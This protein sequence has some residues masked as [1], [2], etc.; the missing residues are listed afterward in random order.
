MQVSRTPLANMNSSKCVKVSLFF[1]GHFA[2]ILGRFV[3]IFRAALA[4]GKKTVPELRQV[5]FF[6]FDDD[7]N[8]GIITS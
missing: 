4:L 6:F 8:E 3:R 1:E 5:R 7:D 2:P